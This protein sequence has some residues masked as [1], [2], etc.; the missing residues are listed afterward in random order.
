VGATCS[1]AKPQDAKGICLLECTIGPPLTYIN[2]PQ[3]VDKCR[4]RE[5][6]RCDVVGNGAACRPTCG[7]DSQ[8]DGGRVCDPRLAVCVTKANMGKAMGQSC[9]PN[10]PVPECAGTCFNFGNGTTACSSPCVLGGLDFLGALDCGGA[11][12]G[13]CSLAEATEGAGDGGF[14]TSACKKQDDCHLPTSSCIRFGATPQEL[15]NG[16]CF[17]GTEACTQNEAGQ[18]CA[19]SWNRYCTQTK[20]GYYCLDKEWPLGSYAP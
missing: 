1:K 9:N 5:D 11:T 13:L 18:L 20:L 8:C 19:N 6:V 3:P 12:K 2:D 7:S 10:A 16:Y 4:G 15:Q 17:G 14:C